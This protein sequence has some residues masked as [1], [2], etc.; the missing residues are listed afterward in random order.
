[1]KFEITYGLGSS[2]GMETDEIE[3]ENEREAEN[4]AYQKA[5]EEYESYAGM[6]G[7]RTEDEI[8]E[9][10]GVDADEA[11]EIYVDE[12]ESWL[13]FTVERID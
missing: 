2:F 6:Y 1:M 5:V 4:I 8:M 9:E 12:R 7:L 13:D 11:Y 3:C 10:D